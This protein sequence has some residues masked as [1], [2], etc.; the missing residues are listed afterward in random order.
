M[1]TM[2]AIGFTAYYYDSS[3]RESVGHEKANIGRQSNFSS[4]SNGLI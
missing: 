1:A 2:E 4:Q 3:G